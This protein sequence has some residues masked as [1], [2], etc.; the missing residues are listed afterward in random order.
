MTGLIDP[1]LIVDQAIAAAIV[2]WPIEALI[3]WLV[4]RVRGTVAKSSKLMD[5]LPDLSDA[6]KAALA[7]SIRKAIDN[8]VKLYR[9]AKYRGEA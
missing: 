7:W 3:I 9:A 1:A 5:I 4:V 6:E 8:E 2:L